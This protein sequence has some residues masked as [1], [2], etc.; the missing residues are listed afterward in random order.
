MVLYRHIKQIRIS[1]IEIILQASANE[2]SILFAATYY[3]TISLLNILNMGMTLPTI[4]ILP[5]ILKSVVLCNCNLH[6]QF[7]IK[8]ANITATSL[9][10]KV[11]FLMD[12]NDMQGN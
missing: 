7:T 4:Y 2:Y 12:G 8:L 11:T 6:T 1:P 3:E 9:H 10:C 5:A